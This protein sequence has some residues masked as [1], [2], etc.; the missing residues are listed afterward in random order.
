MDFVP[1]ILCKDETVTVLSRE[2]RA[3]CLFCTFGTVLFLLS[4]IKSCNI[5]MYY[6]IIPNM[7]NAICIT[8]SKSQIHYFL[9]L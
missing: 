4:S 2:G 9:V 3:C 6:V 1:G 8:A 7:P 5:L